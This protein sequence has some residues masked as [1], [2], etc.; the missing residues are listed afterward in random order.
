MI[1]CKNGVVAN[2]RIYGDFDVGIEIDNCENINTYGNDINVGSHTQYHPSFP[3]MKKLEEMKSVH[4][5]AALNIRDVA[6]VKWL[7]E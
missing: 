4:V 2:N 3:I 6:E 7:L 1:G 5:E